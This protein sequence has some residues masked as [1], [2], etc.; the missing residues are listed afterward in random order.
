MHSTRR[1]SAITALLQQGVLVLA[2]VG[3]TGCK[4]LTGAGQLPAG[5]PNPSIYNTTSGAIGL[6]NAAVFDLE[7]A[8]PVY[9]VE[10]GLLTD[11]L[12]DKET[13]ASTGVLL[14]GNTLS[15]PLD[16]RIL[17]EG[18][19][20]QMV[21]GGSYY[22]LQQAR[23]AINLAIRALAAY[24]T[25]AA[26]TAQQ[27]L[28]RGELYAFE[29]YTEILLADFFCSGIPLS[30]LDFQGDFTYQA[31][32]STTQVYH[33][34]LAKLDSA[35][36]LGV[37]SDSVVHLARVLQGR[38]YL[39]LGQ[40]AAA[41]DD[42]TTVP[43]TFQYMVMTGSWGGGVG[44]GDA[45]SLNQVATVSDQ[46]GGTGLPY[47]SAG[48]VRTA[49]QVVCIPNQGGQYAA[50]ACPVDTLTFP[51]KYAAVLTTN[52]TRTL[53]P[54]ASGVEAR[55]IEAEAELQPASSPPSDAWLTTLN[56]LRESIQL[57]DT[58]DPGTATGRIALLFRERA[59]WLFLTGHRQGDLRRLLRQYGQYS[60]FQSEQQVYPSGAYTAPGLGRYGS[61]VTV[62]I[63]PSETAN[64]DFHGCLDRNP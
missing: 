34:A 17:S 26:D 35:L 18:L 9:T 23:G 57:S 10:S 13:G 2:V 39:A 38:A 46:E 5:T 61:D 56:T 25:A 40:Y 51:T 33:D 44:T 58:S 32:S 50:I 45:N 19:D 3:G 30:T 49:V 6:R 7:Q 48:D 47:R 8:L 64:P 27:H 42:V 63:P 43:T 55:L 16:E 15:D 52:T 41:R 37:A 12:Q 14:T 54:V 28:Y 29:G 62:P 20:A 11:E 36:M 21:G 24:D 4:D 53:L 31:G 59:Y 1:R 22:V 60:A